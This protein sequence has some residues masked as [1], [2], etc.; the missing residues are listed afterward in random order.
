MKLANK[1]KFKFSLV[2]VLVFFC[3]TYIFLDSSAIGMAL[4]S[5]DTSILFQISFLRDY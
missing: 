1:F 2:L 3:V 4:A 5:R